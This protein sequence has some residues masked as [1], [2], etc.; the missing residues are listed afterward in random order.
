MVAAAQNTTV[1]AGSFGAGWAVA[2]GVVLVALII[3]AFWWGSR[4]AS[5]RPVPPQEPQP[6]SDSWHTPAESETHHSPAS[7]SPDERP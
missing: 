2:V 1:L 3:A 5:R 7:S 6:G 4:R